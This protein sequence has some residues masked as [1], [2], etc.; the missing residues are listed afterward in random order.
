MTVKRWLLAL[1]LTC[2][3]LS[4]SSADATSE[5]AVY[6]VTFKLESNRQEVLLIKPQEVKKVYSEKALPAGKVILFSRP[7]E[8]DDY[9][10]AAWVHEG[11][12]Y[13]LGAI[14]MVPY[15]NESYVHLYPLNDHQILRIDGV[16]QPQAIQSNY[17]QFTGDAIKP[18]LR[19]DGNV[20]EADLDGDGRKEIIATHDGGKTRLYR[21]LPNG[22]FEVAD[23]NQQLRAKEVIFQREDD[24]FIAKVDGETIRLIFR[25]DGLHEVR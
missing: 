25:K 17:Y 2:L 16:Y 20:A 24:L 7:Y 15:A 18:Y 5:E 1:W 9:L 8:L 22:Q 3:L 13:D 23:I 11:K 19:V 4:G 6:P 10:Y 21:E 12:L 14:G